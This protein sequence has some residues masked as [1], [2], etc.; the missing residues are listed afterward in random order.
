MG[1][2]EVRLKAD[3]I[4]K[5][6]SEFVELTLHDNVW[7]RVL[8]K[9]VFVLVDLLLENFV[10]GLQVV[11]CVPQ[12]KHL[13]KLLFASQLLHSVDLLLDVLDEAIHCGQ[14]R[15]RE[16]FRRWGVLSY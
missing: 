10:F 13:E 9:V 12:Q 3:H 1:E 16:V 2:N 7:A 6:A 8:L 14:G 4:L 15:H 11:E 5:E